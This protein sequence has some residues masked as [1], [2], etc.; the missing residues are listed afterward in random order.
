VPCWFWPA[1]RSHG[2]GPLGS[3]RAGAAAACSHSEVIQPGCRTAPGEPGR[4]VTSAAALRCR[5][6]N[7][8]CGSSSAGGGRRAAAHQRRGLHPRL[9]VHPVLTAGACCQGVEDA[10]GGE[11]SQY[12]AGCSCHHASRAWRRSQ[13]ARPRRWPRTTVCLSLYKHVSCRPPELLPAKFERA[14]KAAERTAGL[15]F[16]RGEL[17]CGR[18]RR[19]PALALPGDASRPTQ[20]P[21]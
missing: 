17:R 8:G 18:W 10:G 11:Q 3:R 15:W 9:S 13:P 16:F 5:N 4:R 21:G 14:G 1:S 20:A 7:G 12:L 19:G 6:C 2:P